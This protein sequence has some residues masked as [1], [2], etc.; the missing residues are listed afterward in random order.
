MKD[1]RSEEK[2]AR[3][4]RSTRIAL[5]LGVILMLVNKLLEAWE[6]KEESKDERK[7]S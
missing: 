6:K 2:I 7:C 3:Y 1:K 4:Q 5:V